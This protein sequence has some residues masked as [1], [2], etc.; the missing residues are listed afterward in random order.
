MIKIENTSVYGFPEAIRGARNAFNS[1]DKSDSQYICVN[2]ENVDYYYQIGQN[3]LKLLSSLAE[4]DGDSHKKFLRDIEVYFDVTGPLYWWKEFDTYQIGK[5]E[6]PPDW[7]VRQS[8]STMHKLTSKPFEL[9]DFSSDYLL[10]TEKTATAVGVGVW[11]P[12]H[13]L[14]MIIDCLNVYREKYLETHDELYWWQIIYL[15]PES[16]MQ[17]ST[18]KINYAAL[19]KIYHDRK[20][21]RLMEWHQFCDWIA[22]L[23]CCDLIMGSKV[24]LWSDL[25]DVYELDHKPS[26]NTSIPTAYYWNTVKPNEVATDEETPSLTDVIED[27]MKEEN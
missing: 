2:G 17:R 10:D 9:S 4:A 15:L 21:H 22:T 19:R 26:Q 8:C 5:D 11:V 1:W 7:R 23:P 3:D 6:I 12:T 24:Y 13:M 20:N 27:V 18:I 16:Y 14:N 25:G